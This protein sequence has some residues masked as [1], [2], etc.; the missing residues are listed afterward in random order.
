MPGVHK[1]ESGGVA[2]DLVDDHAVR[3]AVERIG[4]PVLVQPMLE[5]G[6]E[7]L[8]GVVQ[9]AVFG[10]LVAFGAG[11][12]M[13]ELIGRTGFRIAPLTDL[14]AEE[15][16]DEGPAGRLVRGFR[17]PALDAS[18]L[19]DLILG[20]SALAEAVPELAELDLNPVLGFPE[21]CV[22]ADAR[23]RVRRPAPGQSLKG[24]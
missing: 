21:G 10:P 3:E 9:D 1:T 7:L 8:A 19:T 18:A 14:D 15:L 20:L 16:V 5:G 2:V 24:W 17:G 11:G 6:V 23:V 13:A 12:V 4:T 22:A